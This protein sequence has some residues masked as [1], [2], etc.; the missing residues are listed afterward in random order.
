V[1]GQNGSVRDGGDHPQHVRPAVADQ[2]GADPTADQGLERALMASKKAIG[3][4][5]MGN[6]TA[7]QRAELVKIHLDRISA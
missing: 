7:P 6:N 1:A 2:V 4:P 5:I 3:A